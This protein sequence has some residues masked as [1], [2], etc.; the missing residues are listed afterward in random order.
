MIWLLS[1]VSFPNWLF[2]FLASWSQVLIMRAYSM[3][4]KRAISS[5]QVVLVDGKQR[6]NISDLINFS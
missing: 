6:S 3:R 1:L 5:R 4:L 2:S